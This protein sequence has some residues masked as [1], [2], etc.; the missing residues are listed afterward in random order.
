MYYGDAGEKPL[1]RCACAVGIEPICLPHQDYYPDMWY[2]PAVEI[3]PSIALL[4]TP[5]GFDCVQV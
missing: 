2:H 1:L 4:W 3:N 5:H